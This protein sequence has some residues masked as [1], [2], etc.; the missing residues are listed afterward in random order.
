MKKF[1]FFVF[2]VSPLLSFAAANP[3]P[4]GPVKTYS[5]PE[6]EVIAMVEVNASKEMLVHFKDIGGEIE[7]KTYLYLIDDKGNGKKDVYFNKKRGSKT[8]V[9][10]VLVLRNDQWA[11]YN[12]TKPGSTFNIKYSKVDTEKTKIED[13]LKNYKP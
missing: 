13:I 11:F 6:G 2:L 5:G 1:L 3:V 4:S 8:V 10:A 9:F 12:P 7:D